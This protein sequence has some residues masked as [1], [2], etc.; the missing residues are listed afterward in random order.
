MVAQRLDQAPWRA[1]RWLVLAPHPDDETLGTGALIAQTAAGS[2]LAGVVYLT[3]GSGSHPHTDGGVRKLAGV[4]LREAGLSLFY[5]TGCRRYAPVCLGWRDA[6]PET[7]QSMEFQKSVSQM[8][9][10]CRRRRV[11]A[12]AVTAHHEPHCDHAAAAHLAYAVARC[13]K[14][15]IRVAEYCVWAPHLPVKAF[16]PLRTR[17]M[18]IGKRRRALRAHRSQLTLSYGPGFRLPADEQRMAA[19]DILFVR[20]GR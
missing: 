11:D 5:L 15:P 16:T 18:P 8:A 4:R 10:L 14:R 9:A 13:A 6:R 17:S 3:D 7:P 1:T 19:R 2:R 20:T 12:I